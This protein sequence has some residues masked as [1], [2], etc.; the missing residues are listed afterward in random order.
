MIPRNV[1]GL[2]IRCCVHCYLERRCRSLRFTNR[3]TISFNG[4]QWVRVQI[5]NAKLAGEKSR[6]KSLPPDF[7][8]SPWLAGMRC[9]PT[10]IKQT[11]LR[12]QRGF[13]YV[14]MQASRW[15]AGSRRSRTG[16]AASSTGR[17]TTA[18]WPTMARP[19]YQS[20]SILKAAESV[21][22][23]CHSGDPLPDFPAQEV[24][25]LLAENIEETGERGIAVPKRPDV[26]FD[27][28]NV[29]RKSASP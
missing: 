10:A 16:A 9:R 14:P 1:D 25:D 18:R 19:G 29:P 27:E 5:V 12:F 11:P 3:V 20:W 13:G 4:T 8:L 28:K 2:A 24:N 17:I 15:Q 23:P 6:T 26:A 21:L 7:Y 22:Q